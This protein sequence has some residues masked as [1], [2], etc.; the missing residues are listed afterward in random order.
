MIER[1]LLGAVTGRVLAGLLD[2]KSERSEESDGSNVRTSFRRREEFCVFIEKSGHSFVTP[3]AEEI[4]F[5]NG[6][7]GQG[8]AEGQGG[9]RQQQGYGEERG[10]GTSRTWTHSQFP[11]QVYDGSSGCGVSDAAGDVRKVEPDFDTAEV[12]AFGADGGG[13]AGAE[14]AGRTDVAGEFGMDFAELG[15]FV[16]GGLVDFLL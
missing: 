10:D 16:H 13:D 4:G 12:G 11:T 8:S 15:E 2:E 7:V 6:L 14:V 3:L 9:R 1:G 5:A